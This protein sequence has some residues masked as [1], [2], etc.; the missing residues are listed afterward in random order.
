MRTRRREKREE[1]RIWDRPGGWLEYYR[2]TRSDQALDL[3]LAMPSVFS[4]DLFGL[5]R[6]SALATWDTG[7]ALWSCVL[8]ALPAWG[9]TAIVQGRFEDM[10]YRAQPKENDVM[11]N[12][13]VSF[14]IQ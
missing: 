13:S 8:P 14:Y 11:S 2:S 9:Y 7:G 12:V 1:G 3:D 4:S 10:A 5:R 6:P